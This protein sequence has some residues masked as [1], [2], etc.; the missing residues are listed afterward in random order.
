MEKTKVN[1]DYIKKANKKFNILI[2]DDDE[3]VSLVL[4]EYLE[5]RNHNVDVISEGMRGYTILE[6]KNYDIVFIDFHLD[7]DLSPVVKEQNI[8]QDNIL[9]G[10]LLMELIYDKKKRTIFGYT[11]DST[12]HAI[13]KFKESGVDGVIFK[14]FEIEVMNKI[15]HNIETNN[16]LDKMSIKNS[17]KFYKNNVVIFD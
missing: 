15:M 12:N 3:N 10:A 5:S 13:D 8:Q 2:I 17:L 4:K 11:G 1:Y 14:P 9:N 16:E 7:N 6:N